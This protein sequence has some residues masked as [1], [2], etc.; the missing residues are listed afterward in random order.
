MAGGGGG[1]AIGRTIYQ[2]P[3]PAEMSVLVAEAIHQ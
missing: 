2:D 1:M 3:D